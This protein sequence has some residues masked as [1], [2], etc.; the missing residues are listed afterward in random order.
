MLHIS[1]CS[2]TL[3]H[4][5]AFYLLFIYISGLLCYIYLFVQMV[6]VVRPNAGQICACETLV[7]EGHWAEIFI[8]NQGALQKYLFS[9]RIRVLCKGIHI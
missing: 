9:T 1:F 7:E 4:C 6:V 5:N 8:L 2:D 3:V